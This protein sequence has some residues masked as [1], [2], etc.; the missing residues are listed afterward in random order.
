MRD[1]AS[2]R[3]RDDVMTHQCHCQLHYGQVMGARGA[4]ARCGESM[5]IMR[6]MY[7]AYLL[8]VE[9]IVAEMWYEVGFS[10]RWDFLS[11]Q[12]GNDHLRVC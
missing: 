3:S 8:W 4:V 9:S 10:I 5:L 6:S 11:G 2:D 1:S 12:L 7:L